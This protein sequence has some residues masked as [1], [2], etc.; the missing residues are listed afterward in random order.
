MPSCRSRHDLPNHPRD[1]G[2]TKPCDRHTIRGA[3]PPHHRSSVTACLVLTLFTYREVRRDDRRGLALA[4]RQLRELV[5]RSRCASTVEDVDAIHRA[6][7][8]PMSPG[9]EAIIGGVASITGRDRL[10]ALRFWAGAEPERYCTG[11]LFDPGVPR[12]DGPITCAPRST[13]R[14]RNVVYLKGKSGRCE[15]WHEAIH[16]K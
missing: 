14:V 9:W 5:L 6:R 13:L 2:I 3:P 10:P 11:V 1:H 15:R 4:A 12:E 16:R 8:H 7:A